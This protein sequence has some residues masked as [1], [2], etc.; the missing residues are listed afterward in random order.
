MRSGDHLKLDHIIIVSA[1]LL[2]T[3]GFSRL[4]CVERCQFV[5]ESCLDLPKLADENKSYVVASLRLYLFMIYQ[6]FLVLFSKV[7][8]RSKYSQ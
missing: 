8:S 4:S 7:A 5:P 2:A 3:P 6:Y 1:S